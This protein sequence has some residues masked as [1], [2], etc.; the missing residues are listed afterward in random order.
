VVQAAETAC[1][2]SFITNMPQGYDTIIGANGLRLS[3]GQRQRLAIARA[4]ISQP[5]ILLLDEATAALDSQ[6]EKEVQEALNA[7]SSRR[8][9]I[10]I[11]HRLSTIRK[12]NK[13][14]VMSEGKI[15]NQGSHTELMQKCPLY[16]ELVGQQELISNNR[17]EKSL[18]K[19]VVQARKQPGDVSISNDAVPADDTSSAADLGGSIKIIWN[20]NRPEVMYISAGV[21]FSVLAGAT[22]PVQAIFFGNGIISILDPSLS[23]GGHN[24]QFWAKMYL[25]HGFIVLLVYC[26]RG[27]CFA[28]S[29][30]QL[31]LRTRSE[32]F[33]AFLFKGL[34][35]FEEKDHSTGALVNFLS[36]ET[37]KVIGV[38][39][40]SL[41]LVAETIMMLGTGIVIGCIFGWKIG[42]V[43]TATV[44]LVAASGFLQYY[45]VS[46]VEKFVRRDTDAVAVAHEAFTAI[47]TVTVLGMQ[48]SV[49]E[50][51]QRASD[52]DTRAKYWALSATMY[53]CT[54]SLRVLS[55]AFVFWYG[56]THLIATG[57]YNIQQFF[58]CFAAIVSGT[59]SAATLFS[60]APD[61]AGA[62][63][64]A[65]RVR[66]FM[67]IRPSQRSG[68]PDASF[69]LPLPSTTKDMSL[70][71]VAFKYPTRP[72][73]L[74]LDGV[75]FEVPSGSFAALVGTTGSGKSSV[76]NVIEQFYPVDTGDI[77]LDNTVIG[78]YSLDG[79]RGY[80]ALVDQN[81]CLVGDDL[82]ESLQSGGGG[83]SDNEIQT[84]LESVGLG[85]FVVRTCLLIF[86]NYRVLLEVLMIT[87]EIILAVFSSTRVKHF[88]LG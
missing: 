25:I 23:T 72:A 45:I 40:T 76:I 16:Q 31:S 59:Q 35:F 3:G 61:I 27:Y 44:P 18:D 10:I 75:S 51:F 37:V 86:I 88:C 30:S 21:F 41:G 42:L 71:Q 79:Y 56:G 39:G 74:V 7:A 1:I 13:I 82:R 67:E 19:Q 4:I 80:L 66:D 54:T 52:R 47:R 38:S 69:S 62:H 78:R 17:E 49:M 50:S 73:Q 9:T 46:Q 84:A 87:F 2:H 70:Q 48:G 8:T 63:G 64:A 60:R 77:W 26:I 6:S 15:L 22:Y 81:P 24:T 68:T 33:E 85:A 29:A 58:I 32:L 36:S 34:P 20:L 83:F 65:R 28:V 5:A 55:I 11:A 57:E 43:A 14:I 12:A 53:A